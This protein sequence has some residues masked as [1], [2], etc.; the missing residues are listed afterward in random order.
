MKTFYK[1]PDAVKDYDVD[2]GAGWLVD[3]DTI[4]A[5]T[6]TVPT[7]ITK[8]SDSHTDTRAKVWISGG[9]VGSSYVLTNRVTTTQGRTDDRSITIKIREQ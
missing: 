2:W 5:S 6:W 4:S 3:D 8:A 9:T 7:G 1:D